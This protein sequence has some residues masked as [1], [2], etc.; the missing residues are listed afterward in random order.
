MDSAGRSR[1]PYK[2]G[3]ATRPQTRKRYEFVIRPSLEKPYFT[4][5][6]IVTG[7]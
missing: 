2:L 1:R 4:A 6:L 3:A 5:H 7:A